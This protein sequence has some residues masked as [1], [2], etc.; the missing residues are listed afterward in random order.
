MGWRK[1][2]TTLKQAP[3]IDEVKK[4]QI[5][6]LLVANRGEIACR[7]MRTAKNMDIHS[8]GVYSDADKLSK[9]VKMVSRLI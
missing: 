6:K 3:D 9:H 7:I 1:I 5:R 4:N 8:V 2:A